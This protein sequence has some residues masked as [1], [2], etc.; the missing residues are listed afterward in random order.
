MLASDR[1]LPFAAH[2]AE[3]FYDYIT[4]GGTQYSGSLGP[5]N[6]LMLEGD[7]FMWTADQS[8]SN[9]GFTICTR[10]RTRAQAAMQ[11]ASGLA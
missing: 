5:A 7:L 4:M 6:V 9:G 1:G 2:V 10:P 11:R 8:I 3:T